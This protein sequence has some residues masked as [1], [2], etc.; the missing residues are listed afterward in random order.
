[1]TAERDI[2]GFVL[3]FVLGLAITTVFRTVDSSLSIHLASSSLLGIFI[4][5]YALLQQDCNKLSNSALWMTVIALGFF[6]GVLIHETGHFLSATTQ[7]REMWTIDIAS[8]PYENS[9]TNAIATALITG[10]RKGLGEDII[11]IFRHSGASHILAL[12]GLHLGII[13]GILKFL[14]QIFGNSRIA[15]IAKSAIVILICGFYTLATGAGASIV[16]AFIFVFM[17]EIGK[18]SGRKST[19]E[20]VLLSSLLIQLIF[21]PENIR[22]VGFQLSYAAMAG[23]A[24]IYP[25]MKDFWPEDKSNRGL[26]MTIL[27]WTWNCAAVSIACQITTA[28]LALAYFGTFPKYFLIT[29]ILAMPLT[30]LIIPACLLT[31]ILSSCGICPQFIVNGSEFLI[32][33]LVN[34]LTV[35]SSL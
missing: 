22:N 33:S 19:L 25:W 3:P 27:K 26:V 16:R 20:H 17:A 30:S 11:D 9:Q 7:T 2:A 18:I 10:N 12:S 28:P 24:F 8:I 1:M 34:C 13:Y 21:T 5:T 14:L 32:N 29:N 15:R 31:L 23:L 4:S 6:S 35:I